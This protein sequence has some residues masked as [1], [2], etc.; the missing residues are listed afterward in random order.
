MIVELKPGYLFKWLFFHAGA[1]KGIISSIAF[2]LDKS[3]EY[4]FSSSTYEN[5]Y[6][7]TQTIVFVDTDRYTQLRYTEPGHLEII[8]KQSLVIH[9]LCIRVS[10]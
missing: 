10:L 6:N 5:L 3:T 1:G 9:C 4:L 8:P 2:G 7:T